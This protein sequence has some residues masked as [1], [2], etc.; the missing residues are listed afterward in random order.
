MKLVFGWELK[1]WESDDPKPA[2]AAP[3]GGVI[4][5]VRQNIMGG[6]RSAQT[7]QNFDSVSSAN[8]LA[9][10]T[11]KILVLPTMDPVV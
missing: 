9:D 8:S 1:F 4:G 2:P 3:V 11:C 7:G 10:N 6:Q 5:G